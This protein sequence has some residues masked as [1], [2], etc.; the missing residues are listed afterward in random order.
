L[1]FLGFYFGFLGLT[2][3]IEISGFFLRFL[4]IILVLWEKVAEQWP[5]SG[6]TGNI[7]ILEDF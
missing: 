6:S 3:Y 4:E 5:S 2:K 1:G 7:E